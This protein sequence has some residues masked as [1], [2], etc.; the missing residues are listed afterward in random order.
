MKLK[1]P[2]TI[3]LKF[4]KKL[5]NATTKFKCPNRKPHRISH[6]Q[7]KRRKKL[8]RTIKNIH[9]SIYPE[10]IKIEIRTHG[11]KH[12]DI[13]KYRTKLTLSMVSNLNN[14]DIFELEY[15]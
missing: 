9:Y 4:S 1:P 10:Y 8:Q 6:R 14:N 12:L 15:I 13:K 11:Y 5:P 3:N 2:Q 7:T